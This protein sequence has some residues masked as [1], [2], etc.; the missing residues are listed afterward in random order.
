MRWQLA[1]TVPSACSSC[2]HALAIGNYSSFCFVCSRLGRPLG[3]ARWQAPLMSTLH[4]LCSRRLLRE[5]E[6]DGGGEREKV[7]RGER[8]RERKRERE[9]E[10]ERE[11]E[12]ERGRERGG[13]SQGREREREGGSSRHEFGLE[14]SRIWGGGRLNMPHLQQSASPWAGPPVLGLHGR[15]QPLWQ[16]RSALHHHPHPLTLRGNS[17]HHGS[18]QALGCPPSQPHQQNRRGL[19]GKAHHATLSL[20]P[21]LVCRTQ[22]PMPPGIM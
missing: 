1:I 8:E 3:F 16:V 10:G 6:E 14:A 15:L 21:P 5:Y 18:H 17:N 9:R 11:R 12:R 2:D 22:P 13:K 20:V 19:H 7:E 4:S